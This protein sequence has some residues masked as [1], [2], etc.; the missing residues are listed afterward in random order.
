MR[1]AIKKGGDTRIELSNG[2]RKMAMLSLCPPS[3]L[4]PV[5]N[6]YFQSMGFTGRE[7]R[8]RQLKTLVRQIGWRRPM[9]EMGATS[10][11]LGSRQHRR[12]RA[13]VE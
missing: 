6:R 2:R 10:A 1:K 9:A 3:W 12:I 11:E 7:N 13:D 4:Q 5:N 8:E